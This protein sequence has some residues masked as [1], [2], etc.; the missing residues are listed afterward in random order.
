MSG[1]LRGIN[2]LLATER[3]LQS[4]MAEVK[5]PPSCKEHQA[6][7]LRAI[8]RAIALLERTRDAL[9]SQDST[10]LASL[11]VEGQAI[12]QDAKDI[13]ALAADIRRAAGIPQAH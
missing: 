12:E 5:A 8:G 11:G 4:R 1:D 2:E 10:S 13:D 3:S 6:R 9:A 7:S